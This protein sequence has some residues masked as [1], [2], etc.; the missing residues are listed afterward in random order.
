MPQHAP[1]S[2]RLSLAS[3]FLIA[4]I[5]GGAWVF[6]F[7]DAPMLLRDLVT[8]NAAPIAYITVLILTDSMNAIAAWM[9]ERMPLPASL[10][11]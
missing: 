6:Y 9:L 2:V 10:G 11:G 7:A 1:D 4:L 5:T 3:W 8:L